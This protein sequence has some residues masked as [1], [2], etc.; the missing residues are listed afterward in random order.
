MVTH[1]ERLS[2]SFRRLGT[3]ESGSG[4]AIG[5]LS[6]RM[7][8][9]WDEVVIKKEMKET[10]TFRPYVASTICQF[11]LFSC[12]R[13]VSSKL[14]PFSLYFVQSSAKFPHALRRVF[15]GP[16]SVMREFC[17]AVPYSTVHAASL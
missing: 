10:I 13:S 5:K 14:S 6:C 7:H 11:I 16:F 3:S 15:E 17:Y 2:R 8:A 1:L 12:L 9:L 4:V